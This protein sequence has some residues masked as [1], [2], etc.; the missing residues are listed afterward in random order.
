MGGLVGA[1][2]TYANYFHAIN[3]FEGGLRTQATAS[4]FTTYPVK[5]FLIIMLLDCLPLPVARIHDAC[6]MFLL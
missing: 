6:V 3:I 4:L 1:A 5:C 2:L